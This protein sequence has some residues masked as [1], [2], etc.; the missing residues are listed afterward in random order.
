MQSLEF[1][2]TLGSHNLL[3]YKAKSHFV[4]LEAMSDFQF[5]ILPLHVLVS[6]KKNYDITSLQP[7]SHLIHY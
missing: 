3:L 2:F 1:D 6:Q 5:L 4:N 7:L